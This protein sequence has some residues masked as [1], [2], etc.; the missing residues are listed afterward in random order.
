MIRHD[1]LE[2]HIRAVLAA[3]A[4]T[5]RLVAVRRHPAVAAQVMRIALSMSAA[6]LLIV[7]ALT[8]GSGLRELR[9]PPAA[10][11]PQPTAI[12]TP[13]ASD[14][15]TSPAA[16]APAANPV[17]TRYDASVLVNDARDVTAL[18]I[19]DPL[20]ILAKNVL[21]AGPSDTRSSLAAMRL[22]G[23]SPATLT[24]TEAVGVFVG[25]VAVF[26]GG[27]YF[28]REF[29]ANPRDSG[30]FRYTSTPPGGQATPI[31]GG[32]G[33]IATA[34]S[35]DQPAG[36]AF[37]T[38]GDLFIAESGAGRVRRVSG[39]VISTYA[40]RGPCGAAL[41]PSS[42]APATQVLICAP[43]LLAV[44][45]TGDLFVAQSG[46]IAKVDRSGTLSAFNNDFQAS[47]LAIDT[48]GALLATDGKA[49]RVV[50]FDA[51]GHAITIADGLGIVFALAVGPD[52]SIYVLNSTAPRGTLLLQVTRLR[53]TPTTSQVAAC[54]S[55]Q[56]SGTYESNGVASGSYG[57]SFRLAVAA[58]SCEVPASPPVRF[59]DANGALILSATP[60]T[61]SG[62]VQTLRAGTSGKDSGFLL[63]QW[64]GHPT[65]P[66]YRCATMG[67]PIASVAVE[68][69]VDPGRTALVPSNV[70]SLDIPSAQRFGFCADPP[71]RVSASIIGSRQPSTAPSPSASAAR[72]AVLERFSRITSEIRRIDRIDAKLMTRREFEQAS[73]PGTST[74]PYTDPN[75][76]I[77]VVAISGEVVPQFG[78]GSV[79]PWGIY[80][81][82]ADSGDIIGMLA[83]AGPWPSYFDGLPDREPR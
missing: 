81:V 77:W 45:A 10:S 82:A 41:L 73:D 57:V 52:G 16:T 59:L 50:R 5:R 70:L 71:E 46:G 43:R 67:P 38:S 31:V 66:G 64:S 56:L 33:G 69:A 42:P 75:Q 51:T 63:I 9:S 35:L 24:G 6:V 11:Q 54:R 28:S 30:V 17:P 65:E 4:S 79:L 3:E 78:H 12:G 29:G 22:S 15:P 60:P 61:S 14:S 68:L 37:N 58:G 23:G 47:G 80:L 21:G 62:P 18:A 49:G 40:G 74:S 19:D 13:T 25:G 27:V 72:T 48:N 36:I 44:N 32:D 53:P 1:K 7:A 20:L 34:A 55:D 76:V 2:G 26:Q 8:V 39:S 83:G